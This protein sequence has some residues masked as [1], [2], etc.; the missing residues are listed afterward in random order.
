MPRRYLA[1]LILIVGIVTHTSAQNVPFSTASLQLQA[2]DTRGT[3]ILPGTVATL[4]FTFESDTTGDNSFEVVTSDPNVTIS[5][6]LPS[7]VTITS[8]NAASLGYT[9]NTILENSLPADDFQ[10]TFSIPG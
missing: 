1:L 7:A 2:Y 9:F 3:S 4:T 5:L 8:A 6:I 10:S